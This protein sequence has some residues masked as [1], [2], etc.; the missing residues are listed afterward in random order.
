MAE[1]KKE[2]V[3][4]KLEKKFNE[5]LENPEIQ[6]I[7]ANGFV[8]AMGVGDIMILLQNSKKPIAVLNL[9]YTVA[10]T[11]AIKLGALISQL[12]DSTGN[13][14]MTTDDIEKSLSKGVN[15]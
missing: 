12:E 7:Y 9:S 4:K 8:N 6:R 5:A 10:K 1:V 3:K 11:L 15:K 13:T 2:E 14:I